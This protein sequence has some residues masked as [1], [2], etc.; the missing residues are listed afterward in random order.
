MGL[1]RSIKS[2]SAVSEVLGT[3]L[4]LLINVGLF[5]VVAI[6]AY[7]LLPSNSAPST[8]II[9]QV[10]GDNIILTHQGG[11]AL[12]LDTKI[13]F[14]SITGTKYIV[15]GDYLDEK[16]KEDGKWSIGE[17]IVY[18]NLNLLENQIRVMVTVPSSN[19]IIFSATVPIVNSMTLTTLNA[20]GITMNSANLPLHYDLRTQSVLVRFT[21]RPINGDW[22]N[23]SWISK[24]GSGSYNIVISSL[25]P[26]K[27]YYFKAQLLDNSTIIEGEQKLFTTLVTTNN[28]PTVTTPNPTN[29]STQ[30]PI[31]TALL[32][33]TIQDP[34]GDLFNWT[35][36]TSPNIGSNTGTTTSNGTKT[37]TITGLAP[38]TTYTW[39]IKAYDGRHWTNK[40]YV[41]TTGIC[42]VINTS[43]NKISPYVTSV[44]PFTITADGN[45]DLDNVS[46]YYRWCDDN[47]SWNG[48]LN[49][50]YDSADSNTSNVDG[51][52]DVGTEINFQNAKG[53]ARDG[54]SMALQEQNTGT[55]AAQEWINCNALGST[56]AGWT[57]TGTTPYVSAK[58][59]P[60]NYISTAS[61]G[62]QIGWFDSPSTTLTGT[63]T[64]NIS[65]YCQ[66]IDGAGNDGADVYV[67]Y[68]GSGS[69][70]NVGRV[71]QH[72]AWQY[73]TINLG[74][75]TISEVNN[76]RVYLQYYKSGTA[77]NVLIDHIRIGL[78]QPSALNYQLDFEYQW[79]VAVYNQVNKQ[80]CVYVASHTG[81]TENLLVNYR[82]GSTW[83]SLGTIT[84]TGWSN[85]TATGLTSSTYTIQLKGATE[86]GDVAQ[87]SWNIDVIMLHTWNTT[88]GLHGQN[89]II[90][91]NTLNPDLNSPWS[92]NFNFPK[93]VGYYEFY[94][95]GKD[96]GHCGGEIESAPASADARCR[97]T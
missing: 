89:W 95:I 85:F 50:I 48:G 92:W 12:S 13:G 21:Y 56:Y 58:D 66:N 69:G 15:V 79:T 65:I 37:C 70:T 77:H 8:D 39:T 82:N 26:E 45:S 10:N 91:P 51:S 46:L 7:S 11:D 55:M 86:S 25:S 72:T 32:S 61:N 71:G 94:S 17:N 76:L 3:I 29:G 28:P 30:I 90:W 19:S 52:V 40:S 31:T 43:V 54:N 88:G 41:F 22:I 6:S 87:D 57:R 4:L 63:L 93:G 47:I 44:N 42:P 38:L 78:N 81:G 97:K 96:I 73:D 68:T 1:P 74:T 20:T 14:S 64:V 62:A 9:C 67:D 83:S 36:I 53:I 33:I 59:Y 2:N 27:L 24:S 18:S 49:E 23:T 34:D 16:S 75:H 35:I 60:T 84:T 5:S 80:V